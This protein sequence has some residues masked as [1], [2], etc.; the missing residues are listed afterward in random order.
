MTL[1][2]T[3]VDR[4]SLDEDYLEQTLAVAASGDDFTAKLLEVFRRTRPERQANKE[5]EV[6]LGIHRSD[7][8]LD[9]PSG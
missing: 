2:S 1:F 8:M 5:Q 4:I 7:Y 9:A 6:V 3:L